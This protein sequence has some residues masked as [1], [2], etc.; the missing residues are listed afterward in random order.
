MMANEER[1]SVWCVMREE[2]KRVNGQGCMRVYPAFGKHAYGAER[3]VRA[4]GFS[5]H[6][7]GVK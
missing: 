7:A 3:A 5:F 2:T 4:S 6:L 1:K